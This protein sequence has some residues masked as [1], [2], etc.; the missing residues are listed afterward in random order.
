[1]EIK[2]LYERT[3]FANSFDTKHY[4]ILFAFYA[5]NF[6][7]EKLVFFIPKL[8]Q[9]ICA[10]SNLVVRLSYG[11]AIDLLFK[12]VIIFSQKQSFSFKKKN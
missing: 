2:N 7:F 8:L 3:Y 5:F 1:M 12:R 10:F 4:L 9:N 6:P 11:D